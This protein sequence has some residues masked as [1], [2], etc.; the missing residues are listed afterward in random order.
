MKAGTIFGGSF[1][2]FLGVFILL[3]NFGVELPAFQGII[4]FW[5]VLL[6]IWGIA[7]LKIHNVAK[8][9]LAALSG[10]LL[11]LILTSL[12][13]S[14]VDGF[15]NVNIDKKFEFKNKSKVF[16]NSYEDPIDETIKYAELE[17]SGGMGNFNF[18]VSDN[19]GFVIQSKSLS[20]EVTK[21]IKDST[22]KYVFSGT[23]V[24]IGES[25]RS[26]NILLGKS[27]LWDLE[28]N[29]GASE[30]NINFKELLLRN[31]KID[32]GASDFKINI[33]D[34]TDSK[35]EISSGAANFN[36][37]VPSNVGCRIKTQTS[38][39]STKFKDFISSEP[40]VFYS[41]DYDD[42][43]RKI[44]IEFEGALSNFEVKRNK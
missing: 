8:I 22:V 19:Y 31:L 13:I 9:I 7:M 17:F 11:A 2:I 26:V 1:L 25:S 36:I 5:P 20:I 33:G 32:A 18:D 15:G 41:D 21:T 43:K 3:L 12:Y 35:I 34:L 10:I 23:D 24:D 42:W 27:Y 29:T 37:T 6:I 40:G 14:V 4:K 16:S 28:L 38:L 30:S 44:N 39:S